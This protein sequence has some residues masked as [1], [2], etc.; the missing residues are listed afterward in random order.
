[1]PTSEAV[2]LTCLGY[3]G[4]RALGG[5]VLLR[6]SE[7]RPSCLVGTTTTDGK[8]PT[9]SEVASFSSSLKFY[10]V[11]FEFRFLC[12]SFRLGNGDSIAYLG[13]CCY[14]HSSSFS[15][16][17]KR[18]EGRGGG[19]SFAEATEDKM[20]NGE[21]IQRRRRNGSAIQKSGQE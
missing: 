18:E 5:R 16:S 7:T 17:Q 13:L 15:N 1:M 20:G 19:S 6:L 3:M 11:V 4:E 8:C 9:F 21:V 2:G 12:F 14:T 10:V